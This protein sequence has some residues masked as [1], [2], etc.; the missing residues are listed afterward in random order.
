VIV[1]SLLF[2][3]QASAAAPVG[4]GVPRGVIPHHKGTTVGAPL[5]PPQSLL[6]YFGGP[7]LRTNE[8]FAIFWDPG[9]GLSQSYRDLVVQYLQDVADDSG[10]PS[11]VYSVLNQYYDSTG[12]IS[13]SSAF[14]GSAIDTDPYPSGCPAAAAWPVCFTDRQLASEV[15]AFLNARGIARP[16]NR[17]FFVFTP[18]GVNSCFDSLGLTCAS[19]NFCAYHSG[20]TGG[21]GDAIYADIPFDARLGCDTEQHPNGSPADPA[22]DSVSHEHREMINDPLVGQA[23]SFGPPLAWYDPSGTESSDKCA[24]YYGPTRSNGTGAY[25]QVINGHDYLLQTEWSNALAQP[26]GFGCVG[27]ATDRAPVAA[28]SSTAS[29]AVVKVDGTASSDPD[30]GDS[31]R[32]YRWLFDDGTAATGPGA[33]HQFAAAGVHTVSLLVEDSHGSTA[34]TSQRITTTSPTPAPTHAFQ[35]KLTELIDDRGSISGNGNATG[36]GNVREGTFSSPIFDFSNVPQSIGV[37]G[38]P[39]LVDSK[40]RDS[41]SVSYH[42]TMTDTANPPLGNDYKLSGTFV[43]EGGSGAFVNATGSGTITGICTSSF[44]SDVATCTDTWNGLIGSQ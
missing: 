44:T 20:F 1:V 26:Q 22:L 21:H 2:A 37:F 23:T 39:V 19:T 25:T 5:S 33:H 30:P 14:A 42:L 40:P 27:D 24:D 3:A 38:E 41:L 10:N 32:M 11:S 16:S 8:T 7:V 31:V 18:A 35:A 17:A 34:Q 4:A 15:D 12:P 29:G 6:Q 43:I 28:F 36:M 13:Y 9:G